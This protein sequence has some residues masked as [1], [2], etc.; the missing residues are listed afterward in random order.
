MK[1]VIATANKHKV[2]E[3]RR[4]LSPH[5]IEILSLFDINQN[6]DDVDENGKSYAE[7]A[8]IKAK[9]LSK[10][11]NLPLISDDSGL[12]IT[13]LSGKPGVFTARFA[14]E[15]G[16]HLKAMNYILSKIEGKDRSARFVCSIAFIDENKHEHIFTGIC[17]GQISHEIHG[18]SG[19][20]YDPFFIPEGYDQTFAELGEELKNRISHRG[21]ALF[22]LVDYL[23][24]E[25]LI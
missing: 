14:E 2:E 20:G 10:K 22:A 25:K 23:K 11:T 5:G 21:L 16:G 17:A 8:L 15:K 13:A 12:E 19:F 3:V 9:E 7:N 18:N 4:I 6:L 1:I 24:V